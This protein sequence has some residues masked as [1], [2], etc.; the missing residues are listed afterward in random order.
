MHERHKITFGRG[1]IIFYVVS[2]DVVVGGNG[3]PRPLVLPLTN[4][5]LDEFD[6]FMDA[7]NRRISM[8]LLMDLA[9]QQGNTQFLLITPQNISNVKVDENTRVIRLSDPERAKV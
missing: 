3:L 7:V 5:S 4:F 1:E 2:T 6:V 8:R 9:M